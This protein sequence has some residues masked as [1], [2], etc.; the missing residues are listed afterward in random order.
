MT[1]EPNPNAFPFTVALTYFARGLGAARTGNIAA[2][3]A[4]LKELARLR[5]ELKTAKNDYWATEV[6][7]SRLNVA[8][9]T[10]LAQGKK[11]D[12]QERKAHR[13]SRPH[14]A[15]AG[16]AWRNAARVETPG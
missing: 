1:L 7:I 9:W 16:I 14:T 3:E 5:D 11:D 15:G 4:A 13:D 8:A 2:A 10:A 6:E 12:G